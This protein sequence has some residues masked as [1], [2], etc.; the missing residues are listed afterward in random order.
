MVF[1]NE[2]LIDKYIQKYKIDVSFG[3]DDSSLILMLGL[4]LW[5]VGGVSGGVFLVSVLS[6][7][8]F[9]AREVTLGRAYIIP[10]G[11]SSWSY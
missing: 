9:M 3:E 1:F 4:I 10:Y 8:F 7:N 11:E 2:I 5:I 6:Y